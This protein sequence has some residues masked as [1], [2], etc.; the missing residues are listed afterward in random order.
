MGTDFG[1]LFE[2]NLHNFLEQ[3]DILSWC[4][5]VKVALVSVQAFSSSVA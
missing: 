2:E 5:L 3:L 1:I 4:F